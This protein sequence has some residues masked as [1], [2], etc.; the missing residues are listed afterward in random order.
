MRVLASKHN[1]ARDPS[2]KLYSKGVSYV[3]RTGGRVQDIAS[4]RFSEII[5][6][7]G[8]TNQA[9]ISL[10]CEYTRLRTMITQGKYRDLYRVRA[11]KN[12]RT[13]DYVRVVPGG[14]RDTSARFVAFDAGDL[15]I[16]D[17]SYYISALQSILRSI[18][19]C[20]G[21]P[22]ETFVTNP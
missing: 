9:V 16:V 21:L 22:D 10:R 7:T 8:S 15:E 20:I 1:I 17:S 12:G 19:K 2:A 11:T 13:R 18:C 5:L 4:Q 14:P 6:S 3:R